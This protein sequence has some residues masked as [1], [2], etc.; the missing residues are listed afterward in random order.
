LA[1][2]IQTL[3]QT[4]ADLVSFLWV[5]PTVVLLLGGP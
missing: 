5:H 3:N 2:L 4:M 1:D